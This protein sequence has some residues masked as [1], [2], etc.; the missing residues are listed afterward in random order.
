MTEYRGQ[1][2]ADSSTATTIQTLRETATAT[3]GQTVFNLSTA[4]YTPGTNELSVYVEGVKQLLTTHYVETSTGVVTFVSGV[5]LNEVV[6][7]V[8]EVGGTAIDTTDATK[9]V[10]THNQSGATQTT[11]D[12]VL[13][14]LA[15]D[16]TADLKAVAGAEAQS[17]YVRGRDSLGDGYSGF[18]FWN[19]TSTAT[20]TSATTTLVVQQNGVATGRWLK[21]TNDTHFGTVTMGSDL[22][23]DGTTESTTVLTGSIQT[24]GGLGVVKNAVIG[25]DLVMGEQADHSSTPGAGYGYLWTK[26]SAP[27]TLFFTDD[28]GSDTDLSAAGGTV[29]V[30]DEAADTTCF[31]MFS[32]AATGALSAKSNAAL[33]FNSSTVNLA[34][35]TFTGAVVGNASTATTAGTVTTAAQAAITSVGTLTSLDVDNIQINGNDISSTGGTDLTITPLAGQQIVLDG[36]VV[37]D[38]GVVTGATSITSTNFVGAIDGALGS[39][40]PA[41]V[42]G[43]TGTFSDEVTGTGFTGTLDGILG[44][45]TPAAATVTTLTST[46][47]TNLAVTTLN[48]NVKLKFGTSGAES[49]LYSDGTNTIWNLL[50]NKDLYISDD[51]TTRFLFDGSGG[52]FHADGDITAASTSVGSD[53]R[54]KH[55]IEPLEDALRRVNMLN[56]VTFKWN[57]NDQDD[58]GLISTDVQAVLPEA[59]KEGQLLN[60]ADDI[61]TVNYN[62]VIGLLV[63]SIKELTAKVA[64]LESQV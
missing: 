20:D 15:V 14:A 8:A 2:T 41:A 29:T 52:N 43:T 19:A 17:A 64:E 31:P 49:E 45:G 44:G 50:T 27:S 40:T 56:G 18:Y 33:T 55:D 42:S 47:A 30:A 63:E 28:A 54:L 3:S 13:K 58:A 25:Q 37:V 57:K 7:F 34:C 36:A 5:T 9:S 35:T 10:F 53:P 24:D 32:T 60:E 61:Q 12:I 38:A 4:L 48:D 22:I 59:V 46:G 21:N 26:S 62:A 16:L 1:G 11:V 39:V 23:V 6:E 51:T